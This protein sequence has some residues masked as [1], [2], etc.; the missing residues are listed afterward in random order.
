VAAAAHRIVH[1]RDGLVERD[2]GAAA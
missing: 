2:G 1:M